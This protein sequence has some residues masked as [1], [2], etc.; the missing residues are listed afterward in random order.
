[1]KEVLFFLGFKA[2][3]GTI[4]YNILNPVKNVDLSLQTRH[5]IKIVMFKT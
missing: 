2:T 3:Y 1:M 4:I 5:C